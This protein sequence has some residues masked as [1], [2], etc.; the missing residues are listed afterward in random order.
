MEL[1]RSVLTVVSNGAH[2]YN[3]IEVRAKELRE[4]LKMRHPPWTEEKV[5]QKYLEILKRL[6]KDPRFQIPVL[7]N[8]EDRLSLLESRKKELKRRLKRAVYNWETIQYKTAESCLVYAA[9][10]LGLD[11][12]ITKRVL[13]EIRKRD[14]EF[15]PETVLD[16]GSG[17]GSLFWAC[18]DVWGVGAGGVQEYTGVDISPEMNE[19]AQL[20]LRGG[21]KD[22]API[23]PGVYSR[24]FLS[25]PE[26]MKHD[27]VVSAFTLMELP[28]E[29]ERQRI[30]ETLWAKTNKYL[31]LI[32]NGSYTGTECVLEGRD[33]ILSGGQEVARNRTE[34]LFEHLGLPTEELGEILKKRNI[35]NAETLAKIQAMLPEGEVVPR[36][37]DEG[38]VFAPCPHDM[39][40]PRQALNDP[41]S[42]RFTT[43]YFP[44]NLMNKAQEKT[45]REAN[46]SFVIVKKGPRQGQS[47][48]RIVRPVIVDQRQRAIAR[49]CTDRGV[50]EE[51][52]ASKHNTGKLTFRLVQDSKW[53]D[54]LPVETEIKKKKGEEDKEKGDLEGEVIQRSIFKFIQSV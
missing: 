29:N 34:R 37:L 5:Q 27:L 11:F 46:F 2:E 43:R 13:N 52:I 18:R 35:W 16:F 40:C 9:A 51:V 48:P 7:A 3:N 50:L 39:V 1:R 31:I 44:L 33:M 42:C 22:G 32:E 25:G 21:E 54:I 26:G 45:A 17:L 14:P 19:M 8:E 38:H 36:V 12:G 4:T 23:H 20:I 47:F 49:L 24:Q 28:S 41:I 10:R 15:T 30:V 53:G 6:D